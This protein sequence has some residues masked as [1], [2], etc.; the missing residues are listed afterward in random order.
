[1]AA[2]LYALRG[3]MAHELTGEGGGVNVKSDNESSDL[4]SDY[5]P[6]PFILFSIFCKAT[7]DHS[8]A[9]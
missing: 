7:I 5:K 1:M 6:A 8:P 3:E 4:I 9:I 2:G